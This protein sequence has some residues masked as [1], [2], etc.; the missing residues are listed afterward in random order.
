MAVQLKI[1]QGA[2]SKIERG[3][4]SPSIGRLEQIAKILKV[5][6]TYF[7]QEANKP[8][9]LEESPQLYGFATK[10]DVE[11]LN[12]ITRQL[13]QEIATLKKDSAAINSNTAKR[14]K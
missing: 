5:D 2:Y 13:R 11:E 6:I 12:N 14:G 10:S 3:D 8:L 1:T 4:S 7:F 9:K